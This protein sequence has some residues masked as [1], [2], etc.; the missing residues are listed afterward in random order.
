MTASPTQLTLRDLRA[1]GWLAEVVE[2]WVPG[3]NVRRDLFGGFDI[4]AIKDGTTCAVQCTTDAHVAE[5][6]RKIGD[7]PHIGIIREA[8]WQ[9]EVW[10]WR[11][12]KG[13]WTARK[14]DV[15]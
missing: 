7:L 3:A 1:D 9:L 13:R 5:R 15:S 11:K 2:R 12:V 8:D 6:V 14:V 10:G 4:I